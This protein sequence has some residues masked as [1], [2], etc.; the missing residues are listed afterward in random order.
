MKLA[1]ERNTAQ[2]LAVAFPDE[3]NFQN[4]LDKGGRTGSIH[5]NWMPKSSATYAIFIVINAK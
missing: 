3:C 4:Q 1:L 2:A 5:G